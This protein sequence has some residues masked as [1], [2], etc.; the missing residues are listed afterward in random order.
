MQFLAIRWVCQ[1]GGVGVSI[2][3]ANA[4][5]TVLDRLV[6]SI[7]ARNRSIDG[8][9]PPAAILWTDPEGGYR[10]RVAARVGLSCL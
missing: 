10:G 9:E 4:A 7:R 8:Q 6:D 1:P 2:S 5:G 3:A